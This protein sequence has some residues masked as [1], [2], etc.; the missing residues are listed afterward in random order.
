MIEFNQYLNESCG[1]GN[2]AVE[3]LAKLWMA[4]IERILN[5]TSGKLEFYFNREIKIET[6]L[7]AQ[8]EKKAFSLD[9]ISEEIRGRINSSAVAKV[10]EYM[11]ELGWEIGWDDEV[12]VI[13]GRA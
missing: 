11:E 2:G 10:T 6:G 9:S 8:V 4:E 3:D 5:S 13:R 1:Y 7:F 12:T